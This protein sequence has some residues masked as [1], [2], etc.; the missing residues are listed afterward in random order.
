MRELANI[1]GVSVAHVSEVLAGSTAPSIAVL[2]ALTTALGADLS[3]KVYP[4]TGPRVRDAIQSRIVEEMLRIAAP[5]WRRWVEVGVT[6]PVRGSVD[7][8]FDDEE[9]GTVVSTEVESRIDRIEQQ[10]RWA[11][12]KAGSL[13]SADIWQRIDGPRTID[14]LLVIRSTESTREIARRFEST[15]ATAFPARAADVHLALT[16]VTAPWPGAGILWADVQGDTAR[17]LDR[18]PRGVRVGR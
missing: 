3:I 7:V 17:I 18:P 5:S 14:R 12:D 8:V 15:L 4:N 9:R 2:T 10:I 13:P 6:R 1:A 16:T 11:G